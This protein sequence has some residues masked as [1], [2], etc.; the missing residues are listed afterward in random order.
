MKPENFDPAKKYPMVVY[1][2]ERLSENL[3]TVP[4]A[5]RRLAG[6]W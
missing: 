4:A 5:D 2:Y 1:I 6:K 3:H